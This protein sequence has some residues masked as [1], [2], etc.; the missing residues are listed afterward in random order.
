MLRQF[1]VVIRKYFGFSYKEINGFLIVILILVVVI[2]APFLFDI[3]YKPTQVLS[4]SEKQKFDSI[5]SLLEKINTNNVTTSSKSSTLNIVEKKLFYFDPNQITQE[6]FQQLGLKEFIAKRIINY[7]AKGGHFKK[8][9]DILKI[10]DF[11]KKLYVELEPYIQIKKNENQK[12]L[13]EFENKNQEKKFEKKAI[14]KL[15]NFDLNTADTTQLKLINGIGTGYAKRIV[16][17]RDALGG[18]YDSNQVREVYGLP[19]ATSDEL[20]KYAFIKAVVKK[21]NVNSATINDLDKHP[22]I[23]YKLASLIVNY[24]TQHGNFKSVEDL[25]HIKAL[26]KDILSKFA[27]YLE[28]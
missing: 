18:F 17:Y 13:S 28:F 6:Q 25:N 20:L 27:P 10:Y 11:P 15:T 9:E 23:S 1:R 22:Y 19:P 26:D 4:S 8:K 14:Q 7:R 5:T 21:I 12:L 16:K 2:I 3:L 24:R